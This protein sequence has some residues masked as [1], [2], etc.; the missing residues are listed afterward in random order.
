[1]TRFTAGQ[2]QD[3]LGLL[4]APRAAAFGGVSTDTRT[5]GPGELFVALVGERFDGHA[6][7]ATA[8][9]RGAV[10]A[11][12]RR[13]T[14]PVPGL[15]LIEVDDTLRAYGDL[16]R[17]R[18]RTLTG[19]VVCVTGNNG[20][21]TTKEM[22]AAALRTRWRTHATRANNNNLVGVPLTILEAPDDVEAL[23]IE[24]GGNIPG[25][26]PR[27]REIVEPDVTVATNATEGH[28]EGY[29]TL[30]A[31]VAD[32]VA[33]T[34]GV[35]LAVVGVEPPS[36][37]A[38]AR[39]VARRAIS[40]GWDGADRT[41]EVLSHDALARPRVRLGGHEVQLPLPGRH[42]ALNALF[43]WVV[44]ESLGLEPARVAEALAHVTVPGGRSEL[45]QEGGL[46]ILND[47]YNA[48]PHSFGTAI[49]TA[50]E[51][52]KGRRLVFVAGT[53]REL[54][55]DAAALHREVAERIVALDP[56]L[57][58]AVG[59]FVPAFAPFAARLGDR[60]I[61]APDAPAMGPL[62]AARL[63]GDE[64][65]VLKGS[66]GAALERILPAVVGRSVSPH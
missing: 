58:A 14:P 44:A 43:A 19:P 33:V 37:A 2:V 34:A 24:G 46:T 10:A 23:V 28:L 8:R 42:Q 60:L 6:Y 30:E 65:V 49:A 53:M 66:R 56:E 13:G 27:Y 1:M 50:A 11:V 35:A 40:V 63:A 59:D 54:G 9:D 39:R 4:D 55:D 29:G 45:L 31:I 57:V 38:G 7:L 51:L 64:V 20:K 15:E 26:L 5:I 48:N 21:T 61:S 22:V 12:V 3:A 17:A 52:R 36:L 32:T 47:C 16:A 62:L 41:P 25:E 18:R